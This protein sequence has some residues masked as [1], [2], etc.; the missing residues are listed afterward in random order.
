MSTGGAHPDFVS[1][2][3]EPSMRSAAK[4]SFG[5]KH[6]VLLTGLACGLVVADQLTKAVAPAGAFIVNTGGPEILPSTVRDLLWTSPT[7]GAFADIAA[8]PLLIFAARHV[9]RLVS[10][11]GR[12][13]AVFLLAGWFSNLLDRLGTASL[14]HP[15]QPRGAIDWIR[16]ADHRVANLADG[17]ITVGIV[18]LLLGPVWRRLRVLA[19]HVPS[20]SFVMAGGLVAVAIWAVCWSANREAAMAAQRAAT[21]RADAAALCKVARMYPSLGM[22]W[23]TYRNSPVR[24]T[25][26]PGAC[27]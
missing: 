18:L 4:L 10:V 12:C 16:L 26:Q 22:D 11:V 13:G 25:S 15:G 24:F 14:W 21:N 19:R 2:P 6:R 7:L 20:R 1:R 5:R 23:L 3:E 9:S 17:F 8:L 27:R